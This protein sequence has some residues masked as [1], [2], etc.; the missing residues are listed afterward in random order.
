LDL[1]SARNLPATAHVVLG[2]VSIRPTA[3]HDL[4]G[5]SERSIGNF[6]PIARS[7][8][9]S[10][11]ERLCR[12]GLLSVTEVAQERRPT[13]RVYEV[14]EAGEADLRLWLEDGE[15]PAERNRNLFLVRVFF[16]DRISGQRLA[17]LLDGYEANARARRDM[18][19]AVVE[20][21]ADR[22]GSA[23]RRATAMFGVRHAQATLDWVS[24]VRLVLRDMSVCG[25]E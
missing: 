22:P 6:F 5:F 10:E 12:L 19:A 11:L 2:L 24:D 17:A 25:V 23:F 9:Y 3:G 4:A 21:L 16:A 20:K 7:Q 15:V 1:A 18:L 13:K 14:T 8:I